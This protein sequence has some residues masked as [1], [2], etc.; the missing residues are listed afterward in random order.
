L[1]ARSDDRTVEFARAAGADVIERDWTDFVDAR[2]YALSQVKTPW[3]L[4]IDADEALDDALREAIVQAPEVDGGFIVRRTT[5]FCGKPLRI[6]RGEP[7]VRLFRT[8]RGRIEAASAAGGAAPL[9]ERWHP[10]GATGE[11][12]GTLLH[13]SYPDHATY[14]AKFERYTDLEAACLPRSRLLVAREWLAMWPRFLRLLLMKGAL[15]DGSRGIAA[16]YGSA[17]Y[18]YVSA[19]KALR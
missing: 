5:Y 9:H 10:E 11:L 16:A 18:R 13:F 19:K 1:D 8:E 6:W 12:C 2:R 7:L 15:L 3:T 17:R 4:M 14:H